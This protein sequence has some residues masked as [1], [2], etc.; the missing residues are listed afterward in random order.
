MKIIV[1]EGKACSGKG[2]IAKK[3]AKQIKYTYIDAGLIF[4]S[5]MYPKEIN[6]KVEYFW[7]NG[8]S[9]IFIEGIDVTRNLS[10]LEIGYITTK[11]ASTK[12]GF[13]LL[14]NE[15]KR[16]S[17]K[18]DKIIIDGTGMKEIIFNEAK[19]FYL[20]APLNIRAERRLK[21]LLEQGIKVNYSSVYKN[22][23]YRDKKDL[24]RNFCPLRVPKDAIDTSKKTI[25]ECVEII[26]GEI[27][28]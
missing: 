26:K 22:L 27:L 6:S 3:L 11:K 5:V 13:M 1:I 4:R 12:K 9:F 24:E 21:H 23:K 2:T 19:R 17:K 7:K 8:K 20:K 14:A 28:C 15:V 18:Y 16:I 25:E 10:T